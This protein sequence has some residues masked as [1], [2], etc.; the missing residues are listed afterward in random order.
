WGYGRS[1]ALGA[2]LLGAGFGALA[3]AHTVTAV[4]FT[5]LIWTAGEMIFLPT[6][7]AYVA[8]LAPRGR[9]GEYMGY[10]LMAWG[11]AFAVAPWLGT[12]VIAE[13]GRRK[14]WVGTLGFWLVSGGFLLRVPPVIATDPRPDHNPLG[15]AAE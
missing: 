10:Y 14:V 3:F 5:V 4:T 15:A 1:L 12:G 7:S 13:I 8:S 6:A 2:A 11:V 9:G